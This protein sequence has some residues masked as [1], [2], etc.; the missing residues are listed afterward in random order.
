MRCCL[1]QVRSSNLESPLKRRPFLFESPRTYSSS[2]IA[3][4]EA[5]PLPPK[6]C[7]NFRANRNSCCVF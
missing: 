3:F 5:C 1:S 6:I 4:A 2:T 7:I